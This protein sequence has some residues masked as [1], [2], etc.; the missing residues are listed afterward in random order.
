MDF[1]MPVP[2]DRPN[3]GGGVMSRS[4]LFVAILAFVAPA[5]FAQQKSEPDPSQAMRNLEELRARAAMNN[6]NAARQGDR[7]AWLN[8]MANL[9]KLRAKLAEAWQG[10]GMS[11]QGAKVVADAYDPNLAQHIHHAQ[12]RGKSDQ[13]I[14]QMMQGALKEKRFLDADQL[15][16]DYQRQK[17]RLAR[18]GANDTAH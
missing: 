9:A 4:F 13:E 7:Q 18:M 5:A 3:I 12:L 11:P 15:L 1:H 6:A 16:I 10:M 17:L 8:S 2:S 14:A